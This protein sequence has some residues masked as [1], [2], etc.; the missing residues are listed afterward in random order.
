MG[1]VDTVNYYNNVDRSTLRS[2]QEVIREQ[3]TS[4]APSAAKEYNNAIVAYMEFVYDSVLG[5]TASDYAWRTEKDRL[6]NNLQKKEQAAAS[7]C[8]ITLT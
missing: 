4:G 5:S 3:R 8:G 2:M 7:M 1:Y 6:F